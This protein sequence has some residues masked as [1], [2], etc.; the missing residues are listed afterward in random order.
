VRTLQMNGSAKTIAVALRTSA[1]Q[2]RRH[3]HMGRLLGLIP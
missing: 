2:P 3:V 1:I